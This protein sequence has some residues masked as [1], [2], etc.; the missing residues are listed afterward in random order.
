[1]PQ[2]DF[3][4]HELSTADLDAALSFY[5][6]LFGWEAAERHDMGEIGFYQLFTRNGQTIGGMYVTPPGLSPHWLSYV[7]VKNVDEAAWAARAGG[8]RTV[9]GPMEVPGGDWTA[10]TIDPQGAA[11]AVHEVKAVAKAAEPARPAKAAKAGKTAKAVSAKAAA[12][13]APEAKAPKA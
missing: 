11:F 5:G 7:R 12:A 10:Q 2:S 8:G 3:S 1:A 4:W 13:S 9:K 6:E